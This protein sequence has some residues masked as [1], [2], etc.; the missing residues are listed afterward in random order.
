MTTDEIRERFL[1]FFKSRGHKIYPSASLVPE[2][3]P[4]LLFTGAGMNQFKDEFMGN[5]RDARR[6]ASC[7]KCLRTAD[8]ERVGKTPDHHTFFEML[9][10]FSFGDYFK[11]E[12]IAWAWEFL[13]VELNIA[14]ERLWVS[15]YKDDDEAY[16]I[17]RDD[18]KVPGKKLVKLGEKENFWPSC[19]PRLGPNG[20]C[21]P[22]SEIFFDQG[23]DVGCKRR[24]CDPSCS[25]GRFVEVWNL[26]FTQ[27]N[28]KAGG[29]TEPLP[30]KNI[31]TG[32]G[33]ERIVRVIQGVRYNFHIDIFKP[34][35]TGIS[36]ELDARYGIDEG[37]DAAINAI[38]DHI[39]AVTFAIADGVLP[40]NEE[41]GYVVRKLIR[42]AVW[43]AK[44]TGEC[45]QP[46]LYRVS[47]LVAQVMKRTYPELSER[48]ENTSKIILKE[49]E[50][51]L[52]T[53]QDGIAILKEEL[54]KLKDN[55]ILSGE[56]VFRLYDTYGLP[57]EVTEDIA[58]EAG[59]S[60][61]RAAADELMG[62]QRRRSRETSQI[63]DEIFAQ[64]L[65]SRVAKLPPTE[66]TGYTNFSDEG[67]I[68]LLLKEDEE[69]KLAPVAE[70]RV[71]LDRT[72]FFGES[73]GQAGDTGWL[74][75][76]GGKIQVYNAKKIDD[77]IVHFGKITEGTF[78]EGERVACRIDRARRFDIMKNHTAT[79]LLHYA[80]KKV[81]GPHAEQAGSLVAP[82]RLRFDFTHF[83]P[84]TEQELVRVEE[85]VNERIF[86][87]DEIETRTSSLS[88]A[89]RG[90]AIALFGE[91]YK[92]EVRVVSIG[93][94]SKELCGGTHLEQVKD[95][96]IFKI[97]EE[98]SIASGVRRI[99]ALTG[100]YAYQ[101][102]KDAIAT[103]EK[104]KRSNDARLAKLERENAK[105]RSEN[106]LFAWEMEIERDALKT[107]SKNKKDVRIVKKIFVDV[108]PELLRDASDFAKSK[109]NSSVVILGD[110]AQDKPFLL[111]S[112]TKDLQKA[113]LDARKLISPAYD[114]IKGGGGGRQDFV[115]A[116]GREAGRLSDA[117]DKV[118]DLAKGE[119]AQCEL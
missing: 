65:A 74:E 29:R 103:L 89:K 67:R 99:E 91:K 6:A 20:P 106:L 75:K 19:A 31:D 87:Q 70:V 104:E 107:V 27:F 72:P 113:G 36:G 24:N 59:R 82:E 76:E 51:F 30:N 45:G 35:L 60:V 92:E 83:E 78:G 58:Q 111:V 48:R 46:F 38:A 98:G 68:L 40:S 42:K 14:P 25:C 118:F 115:Q 47:P 96:G 5:V 22:C 18:I 12:A 73:G 1:A 85:V 110:I 33:L 4:T 102:M 119:I 88:E 61:N 100:K 108:Q 37:C 2:D 79:H 116:G 95:I 62:E 97:T 44:K 17:W 56:V 32:M 114:I 7:Q 64:T 41:R 15:V 54:S 52:A 8:L 71:V 93:D 23:E 39:R 81:L 55:G 109:Y 21:G 90:G 49:E 66:F 50:R 117:L 34:I 112:L 10:N 28:R 63:K 94:Y 9:G 105:L 26:V 3:D 80:L 13:T 16:D 57:F 86:A 77:V 69:L 11:K 101:R 53:L 43:H 84:L